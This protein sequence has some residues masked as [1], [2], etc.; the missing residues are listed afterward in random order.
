MY[1]VLGFLARVLNA[2]KEF[3]REVIDRE[4]VKEILFTYCCDGYIGSI[5]VLKVRDRNLIGI[6]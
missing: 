6:R 5:L 3:K 1:T 2:Q 4:K